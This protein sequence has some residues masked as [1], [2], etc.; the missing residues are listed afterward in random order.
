MVYAPYEG[1]YE[2][3][4][5]V[6]PFNDP[7]YSDTMNRIIKENAIE[8]AIVIPEPEALFWSEHPFSC[9]FMRIPP[10]FGREVLSKR[11]LYENLETTGLTPKFQ[12]VDKLDLYKDSNNVKID[13][14]LWI[15]DYSEGTTSGRG[16]SRNR[17]I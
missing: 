1:L 16:S 9:K 6:P 13:Y 10:K 4:Y 3:V 17:V 14:P 11:R 5:Y 2:K 8:Y 12:V 15:R 7:T